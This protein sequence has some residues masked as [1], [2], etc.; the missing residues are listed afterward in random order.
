MPPIEF[1]DPGACVPVRSKLFCGS[2]IVRFDSSASKPPSFQ[3]SGPM[4]DDRTT[5]AGSELLSASMCHP[6]SPWLSEHWLLT[7]LAELN[8][9]PRR[10]F[11]QF[12][13]TTSARRP[14]L[15]QCADESGS[16]IEM[17]SVQ[18]FGLIY[19]LEH[20]LICGLSHLVDGAR[21]L[22]L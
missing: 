2:P 14:V 11:A 8:H 18:P 19:L 22:L 6:M 4:I 13:A 10:S 16:V 1:V 12:S 17:Y 15:W 9:I 7:E 20:I 21:S 3:A 5:C